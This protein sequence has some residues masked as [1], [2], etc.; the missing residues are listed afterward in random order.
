M[1]QNILSFMDQVQKQ[2]IKNTTVVYQIT[3]VVKVELLELNIE[4]KIN[5]TLKDIL[6]GVRSSCTYVGAP[7]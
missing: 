4:G 1:D 6:G 3:E 5:D 7:H 2:Q